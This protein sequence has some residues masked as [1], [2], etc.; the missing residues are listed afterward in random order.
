MPTGRHNLIQLSNV[1]FTTDGLSTGTPCK[2]TVT[3]LNVLKT[4]RTGQ[5][6]IVLDGTVWQ[7]PVSINGAPI[8]F[9]VFRMTSALLTTVSDAIRAAAIAGSN[10][11]LS[12]TGGAFGDFYLT[13]APAFPTP[14]EF[15]G[16]FFSN[17][18][19]DVTFNFIV[20]SQIYQLPITAG[21]Y[22]ITGNNITLTYS[23]A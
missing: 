11:S 8:S 7:Q 3:G 19:Y 14:I 12:I 9:S 1:Y 15:D 2:T 17:T 13:V 6:I 5:S 23:G 4:G 18:L 16:E 20:Q 21:A 10:I 22:V